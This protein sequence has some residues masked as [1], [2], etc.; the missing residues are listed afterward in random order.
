MAFSVVCLC[1]LMFFKK[2]VT[3]DGDISDDSK[4]LKI[5]K[6]EKTKEECK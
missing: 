1:M 4:R 5:E 3:D 2:D 6:L